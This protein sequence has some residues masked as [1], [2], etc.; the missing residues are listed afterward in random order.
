M[1]IDSLKRLFGSGS[2]GVSCEESLRFM[3]EYLDGELDGVRTEQVQQHFENCRACY[4][5]LNLEKKFRDRLRRA[6]ASD[7]CPDEVR[8]SVLDA[9]TRES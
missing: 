1:I 8:A 9:I 7:C 2:K 5:H 3:H 4:P 6:G